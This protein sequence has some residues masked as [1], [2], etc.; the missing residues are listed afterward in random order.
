M[1][2]DL[3][4]MMRQFR[5]FDLDYFELFTVFIAFTRSL[6]WFRYYTWMDEMGR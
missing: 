3:S 5:N 6:L 1:T 2:Y 4:D